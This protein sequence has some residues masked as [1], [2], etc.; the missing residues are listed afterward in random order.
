VQR[1]RRL[2]RQRSARRSEA[3]FV[4]EGVNVVAAAFDAGAPVESLYY[5][6][7]ALELPAAA[8]LLER[9]RGAGARVFALQQGVLERVADA[10]TP[11]PVAAVVSCGDH[12]LGALLDE[13]RAGAPIL[14]CVA[15]RDPG[16][17]GAIIRSADASGAAGVVCCDT[18]TDPYNPKTVRASAGSVFHVPVVADAVAAVALDDLRAAGYLRA[19]A[20]AHGGEDYASARLGPWVAL[21]LG[22]EAHGLDA[23]VADGLD[24]ALSVPMAG[25]AESL[26]VAMAATVLCF[27]LARQRRAGFL[28]ERDVPEHLR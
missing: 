26:N 18:S 27:E 13:R 28:G 7:G 23:E 24:L 20:V 3:A 17:L 15:V 12:S 19:G 14:V 10:T 16:N 1:L 5:A 2:L 21:V 4:A 22:N 8:A 25:H 9:A 11:Q 6:P